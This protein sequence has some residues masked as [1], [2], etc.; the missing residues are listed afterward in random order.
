MITKD[1]ADWVHCHCRADAAVDAIA[2]VQHLG[3][4][5]GT[6]F[7]VIQQ[8][9]KQL[10]SLVWIKLL[11]SREAEKC[12]CPTAGEIAAWGWRD[13]TS[14]STCTKAEGGVELQRTAAKMGWRQTQMWELC[15]KETEHNRYK[16]VEPEHNELQPSLR[17]KDKKEHVELKIKT[18]EDKE[19]DVKVELGRLR[20]DKDR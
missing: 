18:E 11:K 4:R 7:E 10:L 8:K 1:C 2:A 9:M 14:P 19:G 20:G 15:R 5:R 3:S 12:W 17:T 16:Q 6:S 13:C